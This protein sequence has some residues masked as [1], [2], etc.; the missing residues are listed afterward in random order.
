MGWTQAAGLKAGEMVEQ[1][2]VLLS[3]GMRPLRFHHMLGG[4]AILVLGDPRFLSFVDISF[5]DSGLGT[6]FVVLVLIIFALW[7]GWLACLRRPQGRSGSFVSGWTSPA[8]HDHCN[9]R[10]V[11]AVDRVC[12]AR[13][14]GVKW[15]DPCQV[16]AIKSG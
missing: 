3:I 11:G 4:T 15:I 9:Y 7:I 1:A 13:T 16:G 12:A 10:I 5:V 14:G 2:E 8:S 6:A